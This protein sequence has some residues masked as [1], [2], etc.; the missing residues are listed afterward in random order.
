MVYLLKR[1]FHDDRFI[2]IDAKKFELDVKEKT[3]ALMKEL[4][5]CDAVFQAPFNELTTALEFW[6]KGSYAEAIF[7][8][9]KV[10]KV[11]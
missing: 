10:M 7:N 8:A 9:E 3:L 5:D 1:I 6:E 4:K 11:Y 2:K